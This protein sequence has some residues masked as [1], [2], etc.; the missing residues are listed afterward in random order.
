MTELKSLANFDSTVAQARLESAAP[1]LT[2]AVLYKGEIISSAAGVLNV[3][4]G[5]EARPD[6]L[7]QV[8]SITKSLTSTLAM[9]AMEEGILDIDAPVADYIGARVGRGPYSEKFTARQ[10]MSHLSGLDGD[11]FLDVSRDNDAL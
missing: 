1:G 7:F 9:Q 5:V 8:G 4:T 6:S 11:L 2:F 3:D 10:L